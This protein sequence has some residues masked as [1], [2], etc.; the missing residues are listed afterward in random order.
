MDPKLE[1]GARFLGAEWPFFFSGKLF[2]ER[3]P[4][5]RRE[6]YTEVSRSHTSRWRMLL[7]SG[8]LMPT[9]ELAPC[10]GGMTPER[11]SLL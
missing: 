9:G 3:K 11:I 2:L 6:G 1:I 8:L 7:L 10:P 4:T 5:E